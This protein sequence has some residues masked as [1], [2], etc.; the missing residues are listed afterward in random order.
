MNTYDDKGNDLLI[1]VDSDD[2]EIGT[3]GKTESHQGD[4]T[5]HR[6][7]SV[8]LF[9][10]QGRVLIQQRSAHKPLWPLIWANSCCSHPRAGEDTS[11]AA[12]RR[13]KE[14][15]G[16]STELDYLYKFEYQARW[17]N[18]KSEH[19]L[20]WVFAGH[21]SGELIIDANEVADSRLVTP[22]E[23]TQLIAGDPDSYSPWLKLE[24]QRICADFLDDI[25][26]K[27]A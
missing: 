9:D 26:G 19:E 10:E 16:V 2:N 18:T 3:L 4:G 8:F 20:C 7:F 13:I 23:L 1:L 22:D 21:F 15:L 12:Q 5:L 11:D 6:A 17:D 25:L 24:W 14:E 27:A